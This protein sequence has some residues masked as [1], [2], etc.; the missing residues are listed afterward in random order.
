[1]RNSITLI[2]ASLA[3]CLA[4]G[5]SHSPSK[6]LGTWAV[7]LPNSVAADATFKPD[8]TMLLEIANPNL[9][10]MKIDVTGVYSESGED[11]HMTYQ[12]VQFLNSPP[13]IKDQE[14]KLKDDMKKQLEIGTE[15][16]TT[17]KWSSPTSFTTTSTDNKT[18]TW[19]KK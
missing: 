13:E 3:G 17:E 19:T 14:A 7:T 1:M 8:G 10:T 12:D 5:C 4:V 18:A 16:V 11:L 9:P 2:L 6:L 15:K